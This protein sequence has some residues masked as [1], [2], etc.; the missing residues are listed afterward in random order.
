MRSVR[1]KQLEAFWENTTPAKKDGNGVEV[2][3]ASDET[4]SECEERRWDGVVVQVEWHVVFVGFD[5]THCHW[6]LTVRRQTCHRNIVITFH[7]CR[8]CKISFRRPLPPLKPTGKVY[9]S[10]PQTLSWTTCA[11]FTEIASV[12]SKTL[13]S[14]FGNGRHYAYGQSINWWR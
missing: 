7:W 11:I 1:D 6:V 12:V 10:A 4:F 13:C 14:R 8:L 5:G 2:A 9:C 3:S